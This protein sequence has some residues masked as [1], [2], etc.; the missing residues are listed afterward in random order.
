MVRVMYFQ[1]KKPIACHIY[2]L[3]KV[4]WPFIQN[5]ILI[6]KSDLIDPSPKSVGKT[7]TLVFLAFK[8][9]I[10]GRLD[11]VFA[12]ET[13]NPGSILDRVKPK[14]TKIDI[15]SFPAWRSALK[16]NRWRLDRV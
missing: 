12:T 8:I 7:V 10:A 14:T 3:I 9:S 16:K 4:I 11:K 5:L 6:S 1:N 15:H 13:V 2:V